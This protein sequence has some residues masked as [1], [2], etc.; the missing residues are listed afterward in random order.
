MKKFIA[1]ILIAFAFES[2]AQGKLTDVTLADASS[3][4][5]VGIDDFPTKKALV[6][7]FT[8]NECAFDKYYTS[9]IKNLIDNYKSIQFLLINSYIEPEEA[10]DKMKG[11]SQEWSFGVPYLADKDQVLLEL[12]GAKK[13]PEVFVVLPSSNYTV[14]Y[15][16]AIDDNAQLPEGV[17]QNYL[18]DALDKIMSGTSGP[19]IN[20][21]AVGCTIRRK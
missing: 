17:K 8:S 18:K 2:F 11:K 12:L 20:A 3:D 14:F 10:M 6:I 15:S 13:S 9:R 19:A 4:D 5:P 7:I 1:V 16:G 21:R